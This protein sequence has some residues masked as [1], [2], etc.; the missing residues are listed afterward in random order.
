MNK[1]L[2]WVSISMVVILLVIISGSIYWSQETQ[3][4]TSLET[5][6][7][8]TFDWKKNGNENQYITQLLDG[9]IEVAVSG[10]VIT[11][12]D[13]E[14][15][16]EGISRCHNQIE[17]DNNNTVTIINIHNMQNFPCFSPGEKVEI[18]PLTAGWVKTI[19]TSISDVH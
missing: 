2:L 9:R 14:A 1:K 7:E 16:D 10:T 12:T 8:D 13:C 6:E 17:L 15:D 3:T 11:D 18:Q 5:F 19:K 4:I